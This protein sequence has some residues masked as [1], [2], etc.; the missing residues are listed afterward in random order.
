ME[1]IINK[2]KKK[3]ND[4]IFIVA[5]LVIL[6]VIAGAMLLFR[7]EG[8]VVEVSVDGKFYGEYSLSVN[9]TVEIR[10]GKNGEDFNI[11]V[12]EDGKAYVSDANC[13]GVL[14]HL[15][16]TNQDPISYTGE[17]IICEEHKVV[18]AIKGGEASE[19]PD[20]IS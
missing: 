9:Q 5:V 6:G 16:C 15:K 11:L 17:S 7:T 18:V 13:P 19:G 10:T 3:R 2:S 12:I 14:A 8:A 20:I 1:N 4:M